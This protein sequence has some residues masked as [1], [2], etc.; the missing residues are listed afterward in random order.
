MFLRL[1]SQAIAPPAQL[2][3]PYLAANSSNQLPA[4]NS[5]YFPRPNR[6]PSSVHYPWTGRLGRGE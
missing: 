5:T 1:H 6:R 3:S 2:S 4:H